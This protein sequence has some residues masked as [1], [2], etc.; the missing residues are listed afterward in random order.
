[1]SRRNK[2]KRERRRARGEKKLGLQPGTGNYLEK[3]LYY[4]NMC[5][6]LGY[7]WE[8]ASELFDEATRIWT[9]KS[10]ADIVDH[11]AEEMRRNHVSNA[12]KLLRIDG[13]FLVPIEE[14]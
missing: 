5:D 8:H 3:V 14:A 11:L 12:G 9:D 4:K 10:T 13:N 2:S 1:M 7:P 6:Q